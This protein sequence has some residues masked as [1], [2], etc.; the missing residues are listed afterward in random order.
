MTLRN[1]TLFN[2]LIVDGSALIPL[3]PAHC[4]KA[5]RIM[6]LYRC[7]ILTLPFV[8]VGILESKCVLGK[9]LLSSLFR[10]LP[11]ALAVQL[12]GVACNDGEEDSAF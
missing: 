1:R 8:T 2:R 4:L 5:N 10:L 11:R 9:M 6:E 12:V 3:E 7:R